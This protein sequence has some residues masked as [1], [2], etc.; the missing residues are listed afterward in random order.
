M[1]NIIKV[2]SKATSEE[3]ANTD[4]LV[5]QIFYICNICIADGE[6]FENLIYALKHRYKPPTRRQLSGK[7]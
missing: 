5:N 2:S 7:L 3:N 6:A 1:L 4:L